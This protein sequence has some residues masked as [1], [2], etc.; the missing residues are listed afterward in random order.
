MTRAEHQRQTDRISMK[1]FQ[2]TCN[3]AVQQSWN[4]DADGQPKAS[5]LSL[6]TEQE[7]KYFMQ[8]LGM[9]RIALLAHDAPR[10]RPSLSRVCTRVARLAVGH[11]YRRDFVARHTGAARSSELPG[12]AAARRRDQPQHARGAS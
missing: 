3:E 12:C 4:M 7:I 5:A 9:S 11:A 1:R 8:S 2:T 10:W 6:T